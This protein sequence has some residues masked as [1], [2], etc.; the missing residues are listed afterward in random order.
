MIDDLDELTIPNAVE[1]VNR[2]ITTIKNLMLTLE[3]EPRFRRLGVEPYGSVSR[4]T[5]DGGIGKGSLQRADGEFVTSMLL[6]AWRK[7]TWQEGGGVYVN[8]WLT[9][10]EGT[11]PELQ[12]GAFVAPGHQVADL[13]WTLAGTSPDLRI[14]QHP[15]LQRMDRAVLD[16]A[17]GSRST[18]WLV[19][20][21]NVDARRWRSR[22]ELA[23]RATG[24]RSRRMGRGGAISS[25]AHAPD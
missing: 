17:W 19:R 25:S 7:T 8:V 24:A 2:T 14:V 6:C 1:V 13:V 21:A 18:E 22:R 10:D 3:S 20:G 11:H 23:A 9:P 5:A 4:L 15:A 16:T 12:A